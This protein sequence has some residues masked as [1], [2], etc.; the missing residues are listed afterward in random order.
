MR[1][2]EKV[3]YCPGKDQEEDF[4]ILFSR[5]SD[6]AF[7]AISQPLSGLLRYSVESVLTVPDGDFALQLF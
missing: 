6:G 3:I 1:G 5:P 7:E 2:G 4:E